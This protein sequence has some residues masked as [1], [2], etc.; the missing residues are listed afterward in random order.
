M[1]AV[2]DLFGNTLQADASALSKTELKSILTTNGIS[3]PSS[4]KDKSVRW[5][6]SNARASIVPL[7]PR[8]S[9]CVI[10]RVL[11]RC[12]LL[13][14]PFLSLEPQCPG[15]A[16]DSSKH[17][18]L[19]VSFAAH[20][21]CRL[22]PLRAVSDVASS[23]FDP[24]SICYHHNSLFFRNQICPFLPPFLAR[25]SFMKTFIQKN[26]TSQQR[27]ARSKHH[28]RVRDTPDLFPRLS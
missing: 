21:S 8:V 27:A 2:K 23:Q 6:K 24:F 18:L 4:D 13:K 7:A 26:C 14:M 10:L 17:N 19:L 9:L 20:V 5:R 3:L 25:S 1:S 16:L 28:R 11:F 15:Y 22:R 12:D